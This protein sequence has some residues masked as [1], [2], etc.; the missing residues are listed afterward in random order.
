L[1]RKRNPEIQ[2]AGD[3]GKNTYFWRNRSDSSY[4]Y[5]EADIKGMLGFLVYNIDV[6]FGDPVFQK[7]FAIPMGTM[8]LYW[9]IYSYIYMRQNLFRNCYGILRKKN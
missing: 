8:L 2:I 6:V 1:K 9:Q 5:Y 7:S 4:K 3:W